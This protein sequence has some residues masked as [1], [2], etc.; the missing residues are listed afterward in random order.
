MINMKIK[1]ALCA[2]LVCITSAIA[3]GQTVSVNYNHSQSF[4]PYHTYAWGSNN[5]NQ[6]QNSILAQVAQQNIDTALQSKGLQ[7][8]Q[9]DQKPACSSRP[10]VA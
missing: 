5:T 10:A 7:K 8:V 9:E 1:S 3:V 4:T 2:M 6:I